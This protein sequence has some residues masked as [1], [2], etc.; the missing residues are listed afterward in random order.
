MHAALADDTSP[1]TIEKSNILM[2]GP[3]GVGKTLMVKTLAR[4]LDVPFSMSDCTPFTQAGYIGE[5]ADLCVQR[6]FA[7]ADYNVART[8]NG[9]ICLDEFDKIATSKV[10]HGKDV[11]GEGVQQALLKL[12]EGTTI[13][14]TA[15]AEKAISKGSAGG[16]GMGNGLGS[17]TGG[18]QP[19]TETYNIRTDNI[20]FICTGA[21][22]NLQ[23]LVLDRV[24]KG[25]LGFGAP[26]RASSAT[27]NDV[28]EKPDAELF[29][30]HMPFWSADPSSEIY[31]PLDLV[32]PSDLQK[33]GMIPELIGRIPIT[34]ALSKLDLEALVRVLTEPRNSLVQQFIALFQ[35]YG[36]ELRFT[37]PALRAIAE[38]AV[39]MGTGA[40]GLRKVME[41]VTFYAMYHGPG[42]SVKHVLITKDVAKMKS[43]P[44]MLARG[45]AHKFHA[46][47][48][49][50]EE[51]WEK[52][53]EDALAAENMEAHDFAEF[54]EQ[55]KSGM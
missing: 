9:I 38:A 39:N 35:T 53:R 52:E 16:F 17:A 11:S 7:A 5:D 25:S 6:L 21:F 13:Q 49:E 19:K 42:S 48:A 24:A 31:N 28:V 45:Q 32:E 54:R 43:A 1:S 40:R 29:K 2:L 51:K 37:S 3:S 46:I 20:L 34:I 8:E 30:K 44:I 55:A 15:K 36:I 27:G 10:S 47:I 4:V 26:V 18:A 22:V 41:N 33:Y 23:K 12:I 50:E 14:I